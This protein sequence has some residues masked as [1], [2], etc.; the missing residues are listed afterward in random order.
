M[1]LSYPHKA[2]EQAR[3]YASKNESAK[4]CLH[5]AETLLSL[6]YAASAKRRALDSLKHSVGVF[7]P[8]YRLAKSL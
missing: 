7:H 6:G 5:D 1:N 2:V 8:A 4:L 3:A